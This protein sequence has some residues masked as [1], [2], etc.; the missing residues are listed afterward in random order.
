MKNRKQGRG[1]SYKK[2]NLAKN[3]KE[4]R[5]KRYWI[6]CFT[7]IA[8]FILLSLI[9]GYFVMKTYFSKDENSTA[10]PYVLANDIIENVF[11]EPKNPVLNETINIVV[12]INISY[13]NKEGQIYLETMKPDGSSSGSGWGT[14]NTS[15]TQFEWVLDASDINTQLWIIIIV[16]TENRIQVNETTIDIGTFDIET[17][18]T[19]RNSHYDKCNTKDLTK[20]SIYSNITSNIDSDDNVQLHNTYISVY[21]KG[22]GKTGYDPNVI[23]QGN[24]FFQCSTTIYKPS[25]TILI[26]HRFSCSGDINAFLSP[27]VMV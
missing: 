26:I 4:K 27:T 25:N 11:I 19:I 5:P 6:L 8:V 1:I 18:I 21:K 17:K 13:A 20:I 15:I 3:S 9:F 23:Y 22:M 24:N 10:H 7:I 14:L 12:T 2:S 16:I